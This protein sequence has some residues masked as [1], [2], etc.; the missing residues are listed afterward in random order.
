MISKYD[1][2]KREVEYYERV[3]SFPQYQLQQMELNGDV[4]HLF[5]VSYTVKYE[6]LL[7]ECAKLT[8]KIADL[9]AQYPCWDFIE[10]LGD[11]LHDLYRQK[12]RIGASTKFEKIYKDDPQ[13]HYYQIDLNTHPENALVL[14]HIPIHAPR[15][16]KINWETW[17]LSKQPNSWQRL[18]YCP[19]IDTV[20]WWRPFPR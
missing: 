18:A 14:D 10:N 8:N 13:Q 6:A 3:L 9:K 11:D 20:L 5:D 2:L 7:T 15:Y 17:G 4:M 1:N 16:E 12:Y 19:E